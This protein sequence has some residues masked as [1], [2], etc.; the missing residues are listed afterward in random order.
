MHCFRLYWA[1]N[2]CSP[3]V[4][5]LRRRKDVGEAGADKGRRQQ[6]VDAGV[7]AIHL[8]QRAQVTQVRLRQEGLQVVEATTNMMS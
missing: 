5:H 8:A 7:E 6:A 4:P 3:T 1:C 2:G